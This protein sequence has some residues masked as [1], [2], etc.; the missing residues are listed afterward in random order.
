MNRRL[1]RIHSFKHTTM[2]YM[3]GTV[4]STKDKMVTQT[5]TLSAIW[6]STFSKDEADKKQTNM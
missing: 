1:K 2:N 5:D 4:L 6:K 3:T